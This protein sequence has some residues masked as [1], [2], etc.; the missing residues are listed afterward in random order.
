MTML[1]NPCL[2]GGVIG[3][4]SNG[5]KATSEILAQGVSR[6]IVPEFVI[7]LDSFNKACN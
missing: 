1:E 2:S 6:G 3:V 4:T 7:P 5:G